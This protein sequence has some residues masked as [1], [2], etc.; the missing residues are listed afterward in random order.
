MLADGIRGAVL[1]QTFGG[2][3]IMT[4]TN[5]GR[6]FAPFWEIIGHSERHYRLSALLSRSFASAL[7]REVRRFLDHPPARVSSSAHGP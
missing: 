3:D 2:I 6:S 4:T 1:D 7:T 5:A